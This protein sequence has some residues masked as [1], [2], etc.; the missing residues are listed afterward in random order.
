MACLQTFHR[1]LDGHCGTQDAGQGA[2]LIQE[3]S[4]YDNIKNE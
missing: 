1:H 2:G 3:G 4:T